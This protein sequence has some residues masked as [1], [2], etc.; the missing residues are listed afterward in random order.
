VKGVETYNTRNISNDANF[1]SISLTKTTLAYKFNYYSSLKN[2]G[3]E[4]LDLNLVVLIFFA[5]IV[6][7]V[8]RIIL[9]KWRGPRS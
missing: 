7:Y 6:V 2:H 9:E 8:L 5:N 3:I 1:N 4:L